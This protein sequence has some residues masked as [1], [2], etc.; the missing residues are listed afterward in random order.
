MKV[1]VNLASEAAV[2][3]AKTKVSTFISNQVTAGTITAASEGDW[4]VRKSSNNAE[5]PY[6][7]Q[8][9]LKL[10]LTSV[11]ELLNLR[12]SVISALSDFSAAESLDFSV[13]ERWIQEPEE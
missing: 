7:F 5:T 9:A 4:D 13:N 10:I 12:S 11:S 6:R 2:S 3:T 8:A 1:E